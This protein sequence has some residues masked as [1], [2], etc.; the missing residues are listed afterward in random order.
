MFRRVSL[1]LCVAMLVGAPAH[2]QHGSPSMSAP[3]I[4]TANPGSRFGSQTK[5]PDFY[6]NPKEL[7][8]DKPKP[9]QKKSKKGRRSLFVD[10]AGVIRNTKRLPCPPHCGPKPLEN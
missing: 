10:D 5:P 9:W 1:L 2:A 4:G 7:T 3:G 8:L 6:F